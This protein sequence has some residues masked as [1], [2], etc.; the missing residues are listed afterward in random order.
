MAMPARRYSS[1]SLSKVGQY[2]CTKRH[3][4]LQRPVLTL[5]AQEPEA[6]VEVHRRLLCCLYYIFGGSLQYFIKTSTT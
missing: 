1:H 6:T 2:N 3:A 4:T 5:A